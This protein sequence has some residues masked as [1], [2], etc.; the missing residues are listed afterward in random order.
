[1]LIPVRLD[2][3]SYDIVL[4]AGALDC[5]GQWLNLDRK[6]LIVT[7]DGV[8][9]SYA[10][11]VATASKDPVVVTLPQGEASK[12]MANFQY[13]LSQMLA[14]SFTRHDCVVAVG[15]GVV[16]DLSGF[17]ASCYMRGVDFYNIPTTLLSQV[18]SSIGGKTAIDLDGVK[19]VIGAFYQP[20]R[21]LIDPNVLQT[22]DKRQ[23]HAGL[24]ESIK[25]AMTSDAELFELIEQ[26][27][28][29]YADLPEIIHRSLLI[30][31]D[32]VE[33][34]PKETGLR[35]ILNFGHTVGHAIE[36]YHA[37]NQ[38]HG[39][40]VATGM[41]PFCAPDL[42]SRLVS[43]LQKYDLPTSAEG[44]ADQLLPYV[45]HDKKRQADTVAAVFVDEIGSFRMTNVPIDQI[46][47]YLE[48]LS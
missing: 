30:K 25:M 44:G 19:N 42:R 20:R 47:S 15:G 18:D 46:P 36:S 45:L 31:R 14:A 12:S 43:V 32:V 28:D 29:L 1:M 35:R 3:Q 38:L 17:A 8:P 26:S 41:L 40:C 27:T 34:D 33:K 7:D 5:V 24:A 13:L 22:L 6:V 39:E 9:S 10:E 48:A 16:G 11:T 37:G 21:V 23:L 4:E 2:T